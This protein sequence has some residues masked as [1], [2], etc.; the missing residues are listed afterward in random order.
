MLI[1]NK[2]NLGYQLRRDINKLLKIRRKRKAHD[3]RLYGM[4]VSIWIND[5]KFQ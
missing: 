4:D 5:T 1:K 2:I 3:R